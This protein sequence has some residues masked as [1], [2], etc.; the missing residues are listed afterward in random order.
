MVLSLFR[1]WG[2]EFRNLVNMPDVFVASTKTGTSNAA[3]KPRD[4]STVAEHGQSARRPWSSFVVNPR[5]I[6]FE[7]QDREEEVLLLLRRHLVTNVPWVI[8]AM[9]VSLV[10][11]FAQVVPGLELLPVRFQLVGAAAW[12]LLV[13]GYVLQNFLDWYFNVFIVTDERV[14]DVDFYSLIYKRVS[15][16]KILDL[17]DVTFSQVGTLRAF[18]DYGSVFMQTAGAKREFEFEEVPHPRKVAAFINE[19]HLEEE[20]EEHEGRV[21]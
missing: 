4:F 10:P 11:L 8:V 1:V 14:I 7:T 18:L 16:A 2:L 3:M 6:K 17:E 19:M 15:A 12:Y 5:R 9:V 21:R 20:R 13:L